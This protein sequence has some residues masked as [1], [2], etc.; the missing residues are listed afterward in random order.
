MSRKII[1]FLLIILLTFASYSSSLASN[2]PDLEQKIIIFNATIDSKSQ[3]ALILKVGYPI[4]YLRL[5]NG[6]VALVPRR[7]SASLRKIE[8]VTSVEDDALVFASTM[9]FVVKSTQI[10]PWGISTINADRAWKLSVGSGVKV[11]IIDTGIDLF[12]PD[13]IANIKGGFNAINHKA[14]IN[15][16]NGHGTHV[17]GTI[18]AADNDIGVVGVAPEAN[19]YAVKVLDKTGSGRISDV[20][21]GIQWSVDSHMQVANMS[22][23]TTSYSKAL[24]KAIKKAYNSGLIMVAAAGNGGPGLGTVNYPAK[25]SEVIAVAA[26]D[27]NNAITPFSSRGKEIDIAAPGINIYSTF[28]NGSYATLSGT[29]MAAPHVTSAVALKL[30]L[31]PGLTPMQIMDELKKTANHLPNATEEEQGAGLVDAFKYCK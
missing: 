30:Q 10:L 28:N 26:T 6:V 8:G 25:F 14:S 2:H 27:E 7:A 11:A 31:N 19:L 29:S 20:I 4:K 12:H 23:G 17:A 1:I 21:E 3:G 13:L 24:D 5:I 18:A 16:D 9:P 22:F 15:D